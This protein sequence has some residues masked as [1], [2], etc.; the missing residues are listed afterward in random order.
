MKAIFLWLFLLPAACCGQVYL[1]LHLDAAGAISATVN[2]RDSR[3]FDRVLAAALG[4]KIQSRGTE[5]YGN[6]RCAAGMKR[7][8]LTF[9][10]TLDLAPFRGD[11][12]SLYVVY[13][14]AGFHEST[15]GGTFESSIGETIYQHWA[16]PADSTA[17]SVKIRF[18]YRL[19]QLPAMYWP[20]LPALLALIL[21]PALAGRRGYSHVTRSFY[22][23]GAS[24]WMALN[25]SLGASGPIEMLLAG[26]GL[27]NFVSVAW[28]FLVPL[29]AVAAGV[30]LG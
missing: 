27:S 16:I 22:I 19:S 2:S 20:M 17:A 30:K 1:H 23:L 14:S 4:C 25:W 12:V 24:L 29:L 7:D 3:P 26:T 8:G 13:P 11:D 5:D 15:A 21:I 9:S 28:S 6:F 18:G 10:M